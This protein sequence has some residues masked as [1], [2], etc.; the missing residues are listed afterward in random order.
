MLNIALDGPAGAGKSTVAKELSK[1]LNILYLDTGAMYRATALYC[2]RNGVSVNDEAKVVPLLDSLPLA[3]RYE[4]A[5]QKTMLG[6]EDVSQKIRTQ[7][8]SMAASD[9]SKIPAVRIKMVEM[10]REIATQMDCVLDGRDIGTF[11]LPNC[12]NKFYITAKAEERARRRYEEMKEKGT[13]VP[14]EEVLSGI[15][16]RDENDKN[17]DFAP[18]R[19][20][21]D[22][23]LLDTTQ[24]T[25]EQV[26]A[27]VVDALKR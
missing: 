13:E 4:N 26:V 24:M 10:Q 3:V 7:E 17:R 23:V 14:F 1:R 18:L 9:V 22:A 25:I 12:K 2:I 20:A 16:A 5:T 19:Q 11:V 27:A 21:E 8:L 6:D 15:V